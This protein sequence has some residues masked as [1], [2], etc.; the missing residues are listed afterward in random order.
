MPPRTH[1][2]A[3]K[4]QAQWEYHRKVLEY[5]RKRHMRDVRETQAETVTLRSKVARTSGATPAGR[6]APFE[7][8]AEAEQLLKQ[9]E[10]AEVQSTRDAIYRETVKHSREDWHAKVEKKA[11]LARRHAVVQQ[12]WDQAHDRVAANTRT[13]DRLMLL[14]LDLSR[15]QSENAERRDKL[16]SDKRRRLE[17]RARQQR[18]NATVTLPVTCPEGVQPGQTLRVK[19]TG[20]RAS[21]Q[22]KQFDVVVPVRP[23]PSPLRTPSHRCLG[24]RCC[25]FRFAQAGVQPGQNFNVQFHVTD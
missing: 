20:N 12:A 15:A 2:L 24:L 13:R 3:S 11:D 22:D 21:M 7:S 9:F 16:D 8:P 5:Q 14:A 18:E 6:L 19:S 23:P 25:V 4:V 10:P 1:S 17:E